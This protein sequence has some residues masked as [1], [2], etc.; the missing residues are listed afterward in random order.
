MAM[1]QDPF[2]NIEY[3]YRNKKI[4][5]EKILEI[6]DEII[7]WDEWGGAIVPYNSKRKQSYLPRGIETIRECICFGFGLTYLILKQET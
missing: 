7:H 3:G 4:K 6:M 1:K 2:T 5:R